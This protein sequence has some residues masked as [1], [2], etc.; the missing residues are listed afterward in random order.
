MPM[1][2]ENLCVGLL[3]SDAVW[4][5]MS[6]LAVVFSVHTQDRILAWRWAASFAGSSACCFGGL[7]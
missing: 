7:L 3:V 2:N 5:A 6:A 1:I 4:A